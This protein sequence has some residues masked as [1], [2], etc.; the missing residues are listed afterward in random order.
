MNDTELVTGLRRREPGA[1]AFLMECYV[2]SLWRSVYMRTHG[3]SHLAEDIVSESVLAL[4]RTLSDPDNEVKS[5]MGWLRAVADHKLHDYFRAASR[6]QHLLISAG[7][8]LA[9]EDHEEPSH[10]SELEER[11]ATIRKVMEGLSEPHRLILEWKY[12]DRLSVRE[13]AQRMELTE[14]AAESILFR[15][16]REFRHSI[17]LAD[18]CTHD[19]ASKPQPRSTEPN[20]SSE[21]AEDEDPEPEVLSQATFSELPQEGRQRR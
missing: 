6:V 11:R 7:A 4:F 18:N 2:T 1:V 13:I 21:S 19:Q 8:S 16:R 17:S 20:S 9:K 5:P 12:L 15:A 3:D 14:K 10:A